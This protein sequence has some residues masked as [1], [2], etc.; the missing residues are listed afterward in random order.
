MVPDTHPPLTLA[1][2]LLGAVVFFG[3]CQGTDGAHDP[4]HDKSDDLE[5]NGGICA[6]NVYGEGNESLE[7]LNAALDPF[8]TTF[9]DFGSAARDQGA[10]A[11]C[12]SHTILALV[13]NQ[14]Y[15][16]RGIT[17]DLSERYMMYSNFMAANDMGTDP[18]VIAK[19][20]WIIAD[21]GLMP[22]ALWP[23]VD[24][25]KN[26]HKFDQD[27]AQNLGE[28]ESLEPTV[29]E[30]LEGSS[31][32]LDRSKILQDELY[33]GALP[34]ADAPIR[35]PVLADAIRDN[36]I[37][38]EYGDITT[39]EV[40]DCFTT[41]RN[42]AGTGVAVSP[43]DFRRLCFDFDPTNYFSCNAQQQVESVLEFLVGN[44][45]DPLATLCKDPDVAAELL[46]ECA[47]SY[48]R[49]LLATVLLLSEAGQ[50]TFIGLSS[51]S[52]GNMLPLW[53]KK[54]PPGGGHA[55]A[56]VG[57]LTADEL[58]DPSQHDRGLLGE[59]VF[60][61]LAHALDE[62]LPDGVG[63]EDFAGVKPGASREEMMQARLASRLGHKVVEE[64]GILFFRNSWGSESQGF[65]IGVH[66]YQAVTFDY[67]IQ[68]LSL[69]LGRKHK[70]IKEL[71][72]VNGR[73]V[74][75]PAYCPADHFE[76]PFNDS[77]LLSDR[78]AEVLPFAT[79][80]VSTICPGS[81]P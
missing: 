31:C 9:T 24:I 79:Q 72:I 64:G 19:F 73:E 80:V 6:L 14:M 27:A 3:A 44:D 77:Y 40:S 20:P 58:L 54:L 28:A 75:G 60:D 25:K 67:V 22:E 41:D 32:D 12:A 16:E 48:R 56:V 69:V 39:G 17:I 55:V 76:V 66:G 15:N 51:P 65:P 78:S 68:N 81:A 36:A 46:A 62:A 34:N 59:G 70:D 5:G 74:E 57:H 63:G 8:N 71:F 10:I 45:A 52:A 11:S 61:A 37:M 42:V 35:L 13:E 47:E 53:Y 29:T 49:S 7:S 43:A 23:Y 4:P 18:A 26:S 33:L 38:T 30:A 50:S 1:S 2:A 21:Y